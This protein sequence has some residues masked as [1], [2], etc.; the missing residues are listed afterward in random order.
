RRL[1]RRLVRNDKSANKTRIRFDRPTPAIGAARGGGNPQPT[2]AD[3]AERSFLCCWNRSCIGFDRDRGI[4]NVLLQGGSVSDWSSSRSAS[5]WLPTCRW[6][7][8]AL[9]RYTRTRLAIAA[10]VRRIPPR[11]RDSW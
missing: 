1:R 10:S 4:L 8:Q 3:A 11:A 2:A 5:S 6:R 9:S 7:R